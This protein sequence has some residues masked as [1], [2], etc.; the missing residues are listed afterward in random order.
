MRNKT[1]RRKLHHRTHRFLLTCAGDH[2]RAKRLLPYFRRRKF[3]KS[4]LKLILFKSKLKLSFSGDRLWQ[5]LPLAD[6]SCLAN[7][8]KQIFY[9]VYLYEV[10]NYGAYFH[11]FVLHFG[12]V[13]M[14]PKYNW[15]QA[16]FN[17][18]QVAELGACEND[19]VSTGHG[20]HH[21]RV[22]LGI[23]GADVLRHNRSR[24]A[25]LVELLV[26]VSNL[27]NSCLISR[28][29]EALVLKKWTY[30]YSMARTVARRIW[31]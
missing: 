18:D 25:N 26:P 31:S 21:H 23:L 14:G 20:E 19:G 12:L 29:N 2:R 4:W 10:R 30:L 11:G 27:D 28:Q 17:A 22:N 3:L 9:V 15:L 24:W 7:A 1:R 6:H 16:D 8:P 5:H 13:I